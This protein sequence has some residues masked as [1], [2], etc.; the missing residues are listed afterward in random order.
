MIAEIARHHPRV[1]V[2]AGA[3]AGRDDQLDAL[4]LEEVRLREGGCWNC[5]HESGKAGHSQSGGYAEHTHTI[6]QRAGALCC[7]LDGPRNDLT[8]PMSER[9]DERE[10]RRSFA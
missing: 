6:L 5:R 3:G 1:V 10:I 7:S 9:Q 4:A 8:I 2:V